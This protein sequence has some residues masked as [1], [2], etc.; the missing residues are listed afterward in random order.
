MISTQSNNAEVEVNEMKIT[1]ATS[2]YNQRRYSKPWIASL[3]AGDKFPKYEWGQWV[4]DAG[5]P[6]ELIMDVEAGDV[7]AIG[8]KDNRGNNT[9]QEF[10]IVGGSGELESVDKVTAYRKLR[11]TA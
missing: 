3:T 11:E 10:Y 7:I 6:G 2:S 9:D 5:D 4:G 8:Q 1:K